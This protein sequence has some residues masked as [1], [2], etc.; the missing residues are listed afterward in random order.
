MKILHK[1]VRSNRPRS[2][3]IVLI[4]VVVRFSHPRNG[5]C[6][7]RGSFHSYPSRCS[8]MIGGGN[9]ADSRSV[10]GIG[11]GSTH[12]ASSRSVE[13]DEFMRDRDRR[14]VMWDGSGRAAGAGRYGTYRVVF[15]AAAA[16]L[17]AL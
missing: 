4:R 9:G 11:V 2:L 15:G 6:A 3:D 1:Q 16:T 12:S 5:T 14:V 8:T 17:A 10:D 7:T 13:A